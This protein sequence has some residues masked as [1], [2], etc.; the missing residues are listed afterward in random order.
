VPETLSAFHRALVLSVFP[1]GSRLEAVR[2]F[3]AAYGSAYGPGPLRVDV[4]LA[5][6]ASRSVVLRRSRRPERVATEARVL[7]VLA[8]L[9]LPVPLVLAG[10][11]TDLDAPREGPVTVLSL[12]PGDNLQRLSETSA[13]GQVT[14][15]TLVLAGVARL[16]AVTA[17]VRADAVAAVLPSHDLQGELAA[18]LARGGPWLGEPPFR[19]AVGRLEIPLRA[20]RTPP[21]FSNG[22]YQP[23]NF[24]SDGHGLTGF[25][26]FE[27]ACFEDPHAGMA[28]YRIY[29]LRPL[30]KTDLLERYLRAQGLS[31]A[32]FAPRMAVRCL[33]TLQ[34]E[35]PVAGGDAGQQHYRAHVLGLLQAALIA[36]SS[37]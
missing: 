13:A 18:V 25:V 21:V 37:E 7:P 30:S 27:D 6:G 20:V 22:D 14:A 15:G 29:D 11:A 16:H 2:P 34:R 33:A 8:R 36:L 1:P 12:L 26:D 23:G 4:A 10:P 35:I 24:L 31:E 5:T 17:G 32:A 3:A 9:G 19:D 28:K